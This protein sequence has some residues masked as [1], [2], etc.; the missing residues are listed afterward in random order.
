MLENTIAE[1]HERTDACEAKCE[2]LRESVRKK[3]EEIQRL[4]RELAESAEAGDGSEELSRLRREL[5]AAKK[6]VEE[7]K[8]IYYLNPPADD[9]LHRM[10]QVMKEVG[11]VYPPARHW[12]RV[13]EDTYKVKL[14]GEQRHG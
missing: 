3:Q 12:I 6:Q 5:A 2:Q 8:N 11:E 10:R 9:G 7:A 1:A 4:K 13:F 14:S